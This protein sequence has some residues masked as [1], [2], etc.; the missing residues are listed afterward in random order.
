METCRARASPPVCDVLSWSL[1]SHG[2]LF[3]TRA[4][5][6]PI[7]VGVVQVGAFFVEGHSGI[8]ALDNDRS[9]YGNF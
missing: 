7:R 8:P 2:V 9:Q 5:T 3:L 1:L 6:R 4:Q